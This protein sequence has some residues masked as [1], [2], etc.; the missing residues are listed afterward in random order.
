ML[1]LIVPRTGLMRTR[2]LISALFG[3]A[4]GSFCFFLLKALHQGAGDFHW[5]LHLAQRYLAGQNPY[6]TPLE[7]YPFTAGLFALPFVRLKPEVAASLFFGISSALLAFGLSR[8]GYHRLFV[9]LA[10]PF[11]IALFFAQWSPLI[12]AGAFSP[13]LLPITMAK[14]Q[15]GLPVFLTHLSKRGVYIC[16]AVALLSLALLPK[17]PLLWKSQLG[18]YQH[19]IAFLIIPG[20]L[21]LLALIRYRDRD[22]W[23]LVLASLM[24]MRWFF[25]VLILYLIPKQR[26]EILVTVVFSWC[27]AIWSWFHHPPATFD[28]VGRWIVFSTYLPMLAI[29]LLRARTAAHSSEKTA[30]GLI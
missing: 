3:L 18:Y 14:P 6:D 5:A 24:P 27:A 23:L 20:P 26:R 8:E 21:V 29:V 15:V 9:L 25:D 13:I 11:W 19:F 7:Q 17:W 16:L 30:S 10:Y 4:T 28:Q 22:A 12:M 2:I 1:Q